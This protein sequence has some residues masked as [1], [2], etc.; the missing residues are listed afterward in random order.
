MRLLAVALVLLATPA[1]AA[2]IPGLEPVYGVSANRAGVTVRLPSN[3]CT[4]KTD[5]TLAISKG[6]PRPTVLVARRRP[7]ACST[8]GRA[9]ITYTWEELGLK[10]G[11]A[12]SFANP[13]IAE[14]SGQPAGPAA[15]L[16]SRMCQRLEIDA[17]AA[18]GKGAV[19]ILSP[20]GGVLDIDTPPLVGSGDVTAAEPGVD[21][22]QAVLRIAVAPEAAQRLSAWTGTHIGGR[23]A[24]L[25]DGQVIR[26]ADVTGPIGANGGLQLSGLDRARATAMAAGVT[27]CGGGGEDAGG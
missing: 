16:D 14:P 8:P 12:F 21:G 23:L 25:L 3:G 1:L 9:E 18:P 24:I 27:A 7:D 17:V 2:E 15:R 10:A 26:L 13:L 19:R 11:Q 22:G 5:L 6:Q 4:R 20:Q